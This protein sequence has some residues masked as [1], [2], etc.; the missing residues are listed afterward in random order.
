[1][2]NAISPLVAIG[3]KNIGHN[4]VHVREYNLQKAERNP[5]RQIELLRLNLTLTIVDQLERAVSLSLKNPE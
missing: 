2:D 1:M 4:S 3:L 5:L